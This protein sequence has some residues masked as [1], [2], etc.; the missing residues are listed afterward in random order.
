ML[1]QSLGYTWR[2]P[3]KAW[4][5]GNLTLPVDSN[6]EEKKNLRFALNL[7][8]ADNSTVGKI[9]KVLESLENIC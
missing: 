2:Y 5:L 7:C 1:I 6:R 8:G 4:L 3:P 9:M